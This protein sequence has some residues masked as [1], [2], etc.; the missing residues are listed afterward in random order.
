MGLLEG[1]KT[2]SS[3]KAWGMIGLT[4]LGIYIVTRVGW[5]GHANG[6]C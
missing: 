5:D 1:F 2:L 6:G 4:Y 3:L